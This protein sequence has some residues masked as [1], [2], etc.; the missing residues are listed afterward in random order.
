LPRFSLGR[1][2]SGG[3]R[4]RCV[5]QWTVRF[6]RCGIG[7]RGSRRALVRW[8]RRFVAAVLEDAR[9][10]THCPVATRRWASVR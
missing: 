5:R 7:R 10:D 2:R 8:L 3:L 9:E 1:K 4:A 6:D